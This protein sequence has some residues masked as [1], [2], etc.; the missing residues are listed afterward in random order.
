MII[1]LAASKLDSITARELERSKVDN[2]LPSL[3]D[4]TR[5][6]KARADLLETLEH[7][8][9]KTQAIKIMSRPIL[10]T[11]S[12]SGEVISVFLCK[13]EHFKQVPGISKA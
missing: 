2:K 1:Y 13:K 10:Q 4:F 5:F 9:S 3:V 6:L 11:K 7:N 12:V 8:V